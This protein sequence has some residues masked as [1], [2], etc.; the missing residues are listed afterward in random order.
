MSPLAEGAGNIEA[1]G[2]E[3]YQ[4]YMLPFEIASVTLLVAMIGAVT[5]A[6]RKV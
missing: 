6:R 2:M 1:V 3:L 4:R 5:L